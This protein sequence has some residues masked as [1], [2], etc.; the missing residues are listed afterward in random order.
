MSVSL[1]LQVTSDL[2]NCYICD[3]GVAKLKYLSQETTTTCQVTG[4]YP[5]MAPELFGTSKRGTAVDVYSLGCLYIELFGKCRGVQPGLSSGIEIMHKVGGS[6][7]TPPVI[8]KTNH[9]LLLYKN[10]CDG[11]CQLKP[12]QRMKIK[13]ICEK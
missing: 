12:A 4:T 8:P 10:I 3:M 6:F 7:G 13:A 9:L 11:C 2:R 1:F 5:F